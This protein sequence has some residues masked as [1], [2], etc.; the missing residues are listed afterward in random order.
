[1]FHAEQD[2]PP[3]I[4]PRPQSKYELNLT[5]DEITRYPYLQGKDHIVADLAKGYM[6]DK[7]VREQVATLVTLTFN[8][9]RLFEKSI[10]IFFQIFTLSQERLSKER[11]DHHALEIVSRNLIKMFQEL[12]P[13]IIDDEMK[14][15]I[16]DIL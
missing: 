12:Q 6:N 8:E 3:P 15:K 13:L 9:Y 7:D 4:P 14:K 16:K 10:N 11:Y 2:P 1:M 5:H